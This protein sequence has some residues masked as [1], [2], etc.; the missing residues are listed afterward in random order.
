MLRITLAVLHLIA[1]VM[2]MSSI[3]IRARNLRRIR[4]DA[5]ALK[6]AF[7][8]DAMWGVAAFLWLSTGLWRWIAGTEKSPSYYANNHVFMAKMGFFVLIILLEIWPMITLIRWRIA[9]KKGTLPPVEQI[10]P[11]ASRIAII[12]RVQSLFLLFMLI[13]AV[14]MARGYGFSP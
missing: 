11:T 10:A 8:A 13:A 6:E 4:T 1:L 3:D 5:N 7:T 12:S 14:L 9:S 2:G